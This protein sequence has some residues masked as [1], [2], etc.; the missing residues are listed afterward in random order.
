MINIYFNIN[1]QDLEIAGI[2][3]NSKIKELKKSICSDYLFDINQHINSYFSN[4]NPE[5]LN[6]KD[7]ILHLPTG[8]QYIKSTLWDIRSNVYGS[9]A[10]LMFSGRTKNLDISISWLEFD[11][12]FDKVI[13]KKY[14]ELSKA[15]EIAL[16]IEDDNIKSLFFEIYVNRFNYKHLT[17]DNLEI[18]TKNEE[19]ITE[20]KNKECT[21]DIKVFLDS[22]IEIISYD[23]IC[24]IKDKEEF[25]K[26]IKDKYKEYIISHKD[27]L[28][29][30]KQFCYEQ[31]LDISDELVCK[32][33]GEKIKDINSKFGIV[34]KKFLNKK[35]IHVNCENKKIND[36]ISGNIKQKKSIVVSGITYGNERCYFG[37]KLKNQ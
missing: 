33:N 11:F 3:Y 2:D 29:E 17:L 5:Y 35:S 13:D 18:I 32:S 28:E 1:L 10:A 19:L 25:E 8:T 23:K 37:L 26:L 20:T 27:L 22:A 4:R 7:I 14:S 21:N 34:L 15:S 31:K 24:H 12:S 36:F 16:Y 6:F 9:N 30:Y